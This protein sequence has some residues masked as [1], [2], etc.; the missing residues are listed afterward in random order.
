M[1]PSVQLTFLKGK[2]A[3]KGRSSETRPKLK[4]K[5]KA[6]LLRYGIETRKLGKKLGKIM[7][8]PKRKRERGRIRSRKGSKKPSEGS[9][10]VL[11]N[12]HTLSPALYFTHFWLY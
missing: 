5:A 8:G 7:R 9:S 1:H 10:E 3:L 4:M 2:M 6:T 11:C 12:F